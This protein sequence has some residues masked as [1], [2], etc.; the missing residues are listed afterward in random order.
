MGAI[1]FIAFEDFDDCDFKKIVEALSA[2]DLFEVYEITDYVEALEQ[3]LSD[4][5]KF[6]ASN[7]SSVLRINPNGY[8][9]DTDLLKTIK[10]T[11]K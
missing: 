11:L 9:M 6:A 7:A 1:R 2:L 10:T 8:Y 4:Q 3:A 5:I